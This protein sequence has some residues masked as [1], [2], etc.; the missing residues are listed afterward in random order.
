MAFRTLEITK[1]AE[2][3]IHEGQMRIEQEEGTAEIPL[4]DLATIVCR[5][6]NIR[7]STMAMEKICKQGIVL[8]IQDEKYSAAGFLTSYQGNSRQSLVMRRQIDFP[9][10]MIREV[11]MEIIRQK[12]K[13]QAEVLK[14]LG[15]DADSVLNLENQLNPDTV[16]KVESEAA[17]VY[18]QR[19][20]PGLNRRTECP[21]NSCLNYGY[22][23]VRNALI[24]SLL[25][26]GFLPALGLHHRNYRNT[27][28]LADDFIEPWR[29]M[30]DLIAASN[31]RTNIKLNKQERGELAHVLHNACRIGGRKMAVLSALE[32]SVNSFRQIVL[33]AGK[34]NRLEDML[35]KLQLPLVIPVESA[36]LLNE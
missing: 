7:M 30:V 23:V 20:F 34:G 24:R 13:N 16:D 36:E 6:A 15:K 33:A 25:L 8:M 27:D 26:A 17:K 21:I 35:C 14:I 11:W 9:E 22:A 2:I 5:G 10:E 32:V 4:E 12:V 19:L 3:H 18:F 29:P 31:D 28:N 1:P